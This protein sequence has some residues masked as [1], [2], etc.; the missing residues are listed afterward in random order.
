[1]SVTG[2]SQAFIVDEGGSEFRGDPDACEAVPVGTIAFSLLGASI[3]SVLD[4]ACC[5]DILSISFRA[6]VMCPRP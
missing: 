5:L 1:M 2:A 3:D 4:P 6:I